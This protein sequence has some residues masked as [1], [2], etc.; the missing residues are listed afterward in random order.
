M[1]PSLPPARRRVFIWIALA[2]LAVLLLAGGLG[3]FTLQP[4]KVFA[5]PMPAQGA[6]SATPLV[7]PGGDVF[8]L[9]LRGILALFLILI[10]IT[11]V[12]SLFN[13]ES[14]KRLIANMIIVALLF[15]WLSQVK[16]QPLQAQKTITP[17]PDANGLSAPLG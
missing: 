6:D 17:L 13:K 1:F 10:P 3:T 15:L 5:L 2:A 14:R 12:A 16:P 4:G 7:M 11:I 8:L 9:I